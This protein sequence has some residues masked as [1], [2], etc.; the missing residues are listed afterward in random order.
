MI[1]KKYLDAIKMIDKDM[2]TLQKEIQLSQ[3]K[4]ETLSWKRQ[5]GILEI[6]NA[7]DLKAG[8]H[9]VDLE[10]GEVKIIEKQ[11]NNE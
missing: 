11:G 4:L 3:S 1:D 7:H 2:Q 8:V 5:A 6:F 9:Q 10:T